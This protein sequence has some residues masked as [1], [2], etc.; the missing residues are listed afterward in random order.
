MEFKYYHLIHVIE[1]LLD[2]YYSK[3]ATKEVKFLSDIHSAITKRDHVK[4]SFKHNAFHVNGAY[5]RPDA[6][7][8]ES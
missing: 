4:I 2:T 5:I 3:G 8:L 7:S 6:Y 1:R